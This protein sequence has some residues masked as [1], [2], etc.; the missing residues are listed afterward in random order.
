MARPAFWVAQQLVP[1]P[2]DLQ[3]AGMYSSEPSALPSAGDD[4]SETSCGRRS[5]PADPRD[6]EDHDAE[7]HDPEV[8]DHRSYVRSVHALLYSNFC[9]T[10]TGATYSRVCPNGFLSSKCMH[11]H[12]DL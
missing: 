1:L 4:T 9:I 6:P 8:H 2:P 5:T 12:K 7:D 10:L 3:L 11:T